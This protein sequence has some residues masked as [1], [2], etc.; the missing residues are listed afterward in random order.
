MPSAEIISIGT[1]ILLG[2]IIDT[3]AQFIARALKDLGIDLYRKTTI[4]DNALRI[5]QALKES[6][7]RCD[8]IITSGGLGPTVDDLTREGVALAVG[9]QTEFRP[10]LWEQV[11]DRFR[12][13][14]RQPT[15][16]NKRQ[17]YI[18]EGALPVENPVG[19]APAFIVTTPG[20]KTIISLPGVPR[21]MEYLIEKVVLPYLAE[22][23]Q[24]KGVIKS[25]TLHTAGAGESQIDD[26][27]GDLE[28]MQNPTVGLSAHAGQVDIRIT[29]KAGTLAEADVMLKSV[30]ASVRQ[31]LGN[32]V[33]G[34]D[35]QTL[36]EVALQRVASLGWNLGI[37]EAGLNGRLTQKLASAE[38]PFIGGEVLTQLPEPA[39]LKSLTRDF[40][41]ARGADIVLGVCLYPSGEKQDIQ[42]FLITPQGEKTITRSYGGPPQLAP[43]WAVNLGLDWIRKLE[44]K[45]KNEER[46]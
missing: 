9:V 8:I 4:G 44:K 36:Q 18:P 38:G 40:R 43:G 26:L 17:A 13:F 25:L 12:R 10:E 31:R 22:Y 21:E 5:A 35:G 41:S 7:A 29:A 20:D 1:E 30:E 16:N 39:L 6:L 19:T 32:W 2:D 27:I 28:K 45:D 33:Y 42:L 3:N 15:E 11:K 34:E 23:Y 24:L 14:G 46:D 37:V